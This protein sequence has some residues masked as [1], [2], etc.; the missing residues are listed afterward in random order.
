MK[1]SEKQGLFIENTIG[2]ANE[3]VVSA[4]TKMVTG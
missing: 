4:F 1:N 2:I 3:W